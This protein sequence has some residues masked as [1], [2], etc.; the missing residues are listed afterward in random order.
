M[1]K[2]FGRNPI[3]AQEIVKA[4]IEKAVAVDPWEAMTLSKAGIKIGHVGHLVQIPKKMIPTIL[5]LKP[6][7]ITVFSY[8]NA[9]N[10]SEVAR[11]HQRKQ[12]V[13]LRIANEGDYIYN[14]QVGG[15]SLA[16][17][18]KDINKL[19]ELEGIEIAGLTSF[20]CLLIENDTPTITPNVKSM[21]L[22]KKML[23]EI[24]H[25]QLEMNMPSATSTASI[26][27][28]KKHGATQGEPGHA[29]TGTTPLHAKESLAE[30]PAMTY[31]SE[32]SH[33]YNNEA[34]VFGGGFYPRSNMKHALIGSTI[35]QLKQVRVLENEPTSIDYYGT[36]CTSDV[37]VGDTAIFAFRTQI[38]V[39]HAQIAIVKDLST[40]PK[41]LGIY[42]SVGN[43][44]K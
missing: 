1:T 42:D 18:E 30:K 17:L 7:Y 29:L 19:E 37:K 31:V 28:L 22:A 21:H 24:G 2:Q 39:T 33:V 4:G 34:F 16:D 11:Q 43:Q 25:T 32:V 8:E 9:K 23:E 6:D 36:I 15:F 41:L 5:N 26:P 35:N 10:I 44:I 13:F 14:G 27:L 20:P 40:S 3:V 38:F 12:K